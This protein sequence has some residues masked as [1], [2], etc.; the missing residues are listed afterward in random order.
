MP[1]PS[2]S[3]KTDRWLDEALDALRYQGFAVVEDVLSPAFCDRA[4]TALYKARDG[5]YAELGEDRLRAA[6]ELGTLRLPLRYDETFFAFLEVPEV[7][8]LID[9]TVGPTAIL[10]LMNGFIL[11][12]LERTATPTTYQNSFHRDFPRYMQGYLAS[13]NTLFAVDTFTAENG[14]T[15]AVPATHQRDERPSEEYLNNNVVPVEAPQGSMLVFDSTLWHSA[16]RNNSGRDRAAL[17]MQFTRSFF[18]QQIDYVRALG[19]SVIESL[20]ERSKQLLGWYTRVVTSL[21]EFYQPA[22]RRMYRGGQG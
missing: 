1:V 17:N 4:R 7:L 9:A 19:D 12:S 22:D 20:P 10:H 8:A 18:K 15:L 2:I 14:A 21:D 5:I 3:C 16:G 6:G 13:I 11:P